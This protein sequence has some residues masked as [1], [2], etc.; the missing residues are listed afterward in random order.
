MG[1]PRF[2][3][4]SILRG[5]VDHDVEFIVVGNVSAMLQGAPIAT[6]DLDIVHRRVPE[7][8]HR[9]L[10]A[11][12]KLDAHYREHKTRKLRPKL[13]YLESPGHQL[14]STQFG[15][16]DVLGAIGEN[17]TYDDLLPHIIEF[18]TADMRLKLLT[19]EKLIKLKEAAGRE[20]DIAVLPVLRR[21]LKAKRTQ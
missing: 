17:L 6:F 18:R 5:L 11:L 1:K 3:A 10:A 13:S 19:L 14:L 15:P 8:L 4:R 7:N 9:L 2:S 12:E 20:K 21:A 16:L